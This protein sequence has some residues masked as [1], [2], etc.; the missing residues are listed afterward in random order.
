MLRSADRVRITAQLIYAPNDSNLWAQG[1]DGDLRDVLRLQSSVARAIANQIQL[2][3]TADEVV[4]LRRARLINRRA[5]DAN[6][7]GR[8]HLQK[9]AAQYAHKDTKLSSAGE[10]VKAIAYFEQAIQEDPNYAPAYRGLSD[11]LLSQLGPEFADKARAALSKAIALDDAADDHL[12]MARLRMQFEYDWLG[13]ELEFK[14]ALALNP[15]SVDGHSS[16][17]DYLHYVRRENDENKEREIAQQLDPNRDRLGLLGEYGFRSNWNLEEDTRYLD[18]KAPSQGFARGVLAT[19]YLR[20]GKQKEAVEQYEKCMILYGYL[21]FAQV[22]RDGLREGNH[23]AALRRWIRTVD[24]SSKTEDVPP[25]LPAYVYSS[26]DDKDRAFEWL[27]KAYEQR[28]WCLLDL[29]HDRIWDPL[30]SD[31]R[32][33]QLLAKIGLR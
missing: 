12:A 29:K 14:L 2:K 21:E 32:F 16:Y 20:E 25:F 17:A 3:M 24:E 10:L 1:Y 8:Y 27:Q 31:P 33:V 5:L 6:L 18:E 13:A 22:L 11:A 15:N 23:R 4:R 7:D 26:L 30:R 9:W 28:N 19:N